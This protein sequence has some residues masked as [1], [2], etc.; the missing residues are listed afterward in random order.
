MQLM[1]SSS[2]SRLSSTTRF[3]PARIDIGVDQHDLEAFGKQR[4]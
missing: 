2:A 3:L 4:R 1:P